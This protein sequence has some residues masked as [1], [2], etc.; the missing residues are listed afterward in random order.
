MHGMSQAGAARRERVAALSAAD[1]LHPMVAVK[2]WGNP[3]W[4]TFRLNFLG[5]QFNLP[6]YGWIEERYGLVRPQYAVLYALGLRDGITAKDVCASTG[7]PKNTIS[8][9][10]QNLLCRKLIR[11]VPDTRDRRSFV[12]RLAA[13]GRRI[14][15]ETVPSLV[16]REK[17]MLAGLSRSEQRVLASLLGCMV[18]ESRHWPNELAGGMT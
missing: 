4:F 18:V 8:R 2:L 13:E 3:C 14:V 1:E 10:I 5:L 16:A 11:R 15:D 9:A 7:F 17:R 6:V 12:L